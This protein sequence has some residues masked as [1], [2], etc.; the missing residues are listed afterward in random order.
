MHD[1]GDDQ[2]ARRAAHAQISLAILVAQADGF[3][4]PAETKAILKRAAE[5][6]PGTC[7]ADVE[8]VGR[9]ARTLVDAKGLA[10]AVERYA[11]DLPSQ[12]SRFQ[13]LRFAVEV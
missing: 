3:E 9:D 4:D 12:L 7:A 11:E 2:A 6:L 8:A 10:A 5:R 1:Q 13:A